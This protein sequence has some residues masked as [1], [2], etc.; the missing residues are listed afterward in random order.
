M[1]LQYPPSLVSRRLLRSMLCFF[2]R[3]TRSPTMVSPSCAWARGKGSHR[4]SPGGGSPPRLVPGPQSPG[5][6]RSAHASG[7]NRAT[8]LIDA[9]ELT[10]YKSSR[11]F[12]TSA[13]L[14]RRSTR[15]HRSGSCAR[16]RPMNRPPFGRGDR[17]TWHVGAGPTRLRLAPNPGEVLVVLR[18]QVLRHGRLTARG[19]LRATASSARRRRDER[20][21]SSALP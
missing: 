6:V 16:C 12:Q 15:R 11:A 18:V 3:K 8:G 13:R 7:L 14:A 9:A 4:W 20:R 5:P 2:L 21:P 1:P 17:R 10:S 19:G